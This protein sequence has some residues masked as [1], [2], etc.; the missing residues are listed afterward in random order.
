MR[1]AIF[2][3]PGLENL[4]IQ[5]DIEQPKITDHDVLIRVKMVGV[6]PVDHITVSGIPEVK[7]L[8]HIPGAE[9]SGVIE[10]VG[11]H[12]TSL[13][14][15]DRV[16]VYNKVFDG[17]CDMCMGGDEMLCRNGGLI[18]VVTDGGFAEYIAVPEKNAFKIPD[19]MQ[20][21][22]AASL[23]VTTLTP[24]HGLKRAALKINEFLVIFGASGNTGMMATQFG[25]KM[26]AKVIAVSK[27]NW[28]KDFG[29]DYI[30]TEYDRVAEKVKDLTQ[31]K[32]AD[33]VLNSL[34]VQ[35]WEN[36][37]ASVG[38]N[39][40]L[41]TFGGLTD[42]DVK[43]NVQS[44]YSKQIKIIGCNGGTRKEMTE[45]IDMSKEL[46]TRVWKKFR[47]D[48]AKEAL[49]ALFAKER[50]GRILLNVN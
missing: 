45:V 24:Y 18:G 10:E 21:E 6:N 14:T 26:G 7:P 44:L 3:K 47:L 1:A 12:V 32:M 4:K 17:I 20:W 9:T 33:V 37:F 36:S 29:A 35:T 15:G 19:E 28:I 31:G 11:Q 16:V 22:L 13:K 43:L 40:R 46:K 27:D 25:K 49:Q 5:H 41:V 42:A 30:I 23:P 2:E 50:D 39:G 8:P 34:G 48:E 38:L